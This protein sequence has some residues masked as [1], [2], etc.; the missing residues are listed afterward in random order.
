[1]SLLYPVTLA[2][3]HRM[4]GQV[5]R[6]APEATVKA[7]LAAHG[8]E[9]TRID[10]VR[11][12]IYET[13]VRDELA[14]AELRRAALAAGVHVRVGDGRPCSVRVNLDGLTDDDLD[15]ARAM[16]GRGVDP[17]TVARWV[18]GR[19]ALRHAEAAG[20]PVLASAA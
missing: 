4:D 18:E 20:L 19:R 10:D 17:R 1:M 15:D 8:L 2:V 9:A 7:L 12:L 14:T 11:G 3:L 6:Y 5:R 13:A 16:L